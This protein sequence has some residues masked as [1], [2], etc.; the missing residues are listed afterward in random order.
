MIRRS[1]SLN[2]HM[3]WVNK[4][5]LLRRAD[6]MHNIILLWW[7]WMS[8]STLVIILLS[9]VYWSLSHF[10]RC[11][12]WITLLVWHLLRLLL[13]LYSASHFVVVLVKRLFSYRLLLEPH[14][15]RL[16][17]L[18]A[19]MTNRLLNGRIWMVLD[20]VLFLLDH[21]QHLVFSNH[22]S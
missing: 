2:I 16:C 4:S 7:S 13:L 3:S 18:I 22:F 19:L 6:S 17:L 12:L 8:H 1:S 10:V 15:M 9:I 20:R 11:N 14:L 5:L 21:P